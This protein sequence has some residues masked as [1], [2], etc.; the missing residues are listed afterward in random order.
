VSEEDAIVRRS[1]RFWRAIPVALCGLILLTEEA[2]A[3]STAGEPLQP[4]LAVSLVVGKSAVLD[5]PRKLTRASITDPGIASVVV[6]SP[7]QVLINGSTAGVTS[8]AVWDEQDQPQIFDV[9]VQAD[10]SQLV[11]LLRE[12]APTD[13]ITVYAAHHS[14][15]LT[16]EVGRPTTVTKAQEVAETFSPHV[17][18]LLRVA[19]TPQ[20][21]LKVRFVEVNRTA[22]QK[23]G[24]DFVVEGMPGGPHPYVAVSQA[25]RTGLA[26]EDGLAGVAGLLFPG[27]AQLFGKGD[28]GKGTGRTVFAPSLNLLA[29]RNLLRLL[30]EPN[31]L[32][33]SGEEASF[34]AGGELPIPVVTANSVK[35]EFKEFGVR[36]TFTPEVTETGAIQLTVSPEVSSLDFSNAVTLAGFAIPGLR[37]RKA[38]TTV[39][40]QDGETLIIGG[41]FSQEMTKVAARIPM[42]SDIP[43]L[44][45]LFK[46]DSFQKGETELLVLVSP[47]LVRPNRAIPTTPLRAE[48]D[49]APFLEPGQAPFG[50]AQGR[51]LRRSLGAPDGAVWEPEREAEPFLTRRHELR[52][53]EPLLR[54]QE[55]LDPRRLPPDA[56]LDRSQGA[57]LDPSRGPYDQ[58]SYTTLRKYQ[59]VAGDPA[60]HE[61]PR[62]LQQ[63]LHGDSRTEPQQEERYGLW[64]VF[65]Y[66]SP[67]W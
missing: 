58:E 41:L 23:L 51:R 16:G 11:S 21:M 7:T 53:R 4:F 34:L 40:L 54:E 50:D 46:S 1:R 49:L 52:E 42:V 31:L 15:V 3:A 28:V 44:G 5:F 63:R 29:E 65:G 30:A 26:F 61:I 59:L 66:R 22:L 24:I 39:E 55:P 27:S 60:Y 38:D 6:L 62:V 20:I 43:V 64:E 36:L 35:V 57:V 8:L 2:S 17:V 33:K 47:A 48:Q 14:I 18:N 56:R 10:T 13:Q 45:D 9:N 37:T 19:Q 32:A 12:V 25:G 67:S